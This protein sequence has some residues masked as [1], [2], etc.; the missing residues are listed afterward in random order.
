MDNVPRDINKTWIDPVPGGTGGMGSTGVDYVLLLANIIS[1]IKLHSSIMQVTHFLS[2]AYV[3][4]LK[5]LF[6]P[7]F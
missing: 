4:P 2:M 1:V 3:N 5:K 6:F 7:G